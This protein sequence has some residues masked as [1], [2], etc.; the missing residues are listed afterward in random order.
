R[1]L[2][3]LPH[4]PV[5]GGRPGPESPDLQDRRQSGRCVRAGGHGH[6]AA[7][8]RHLGHRRAA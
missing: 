5:R 4:H 1:R 7:G 8:R 6:R 3:P 2:H